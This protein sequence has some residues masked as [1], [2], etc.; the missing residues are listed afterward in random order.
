MR[1]VIILALTVLAGV[2]AFA[3]TTSQYTL[4]DG[5]IL[6]IKAQ[7]AVWSGQKTKCTLSG[8]AHLSASNKAAATSVDAKANKIV[9][10]VYRNTDEQKAAGAK[11]GIKSIELTGSPKVEFVAPEAVNDPITG[12]KTGMVITKTHA[13]AD[14]ITYAGSTGIADLIGSVEI[15]ANDP[16]RSPEPMIATGDRAAINVQHL[17]TQE[18]FDFR[19]ENAEIH[20]VPTLEQTGKK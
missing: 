12:K 1:A 16:S 20:I 15:N 13:S 7:S 18:D 4:P 2:S 17:P 6:D 11:D 19:L 3:A 10:V 14:S 9:V 8:G 5:T